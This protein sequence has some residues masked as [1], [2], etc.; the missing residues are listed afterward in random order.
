MTMK[1]I[2]TT[3]AIALAGALTAATAKAQVCSNL[4]L[5]GTFA[6]TITGSITAPPALAGPFASVGTQTFDG[7]GGTTAKAM[8]SQNGTIIPVTITGTYSVNPDCTGTFTL[9]ISPLGLTTHTFF[10][11]DHVIDYGETEF[12]AVLT[13]PGL[14]VTGIARRLFP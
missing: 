14:V 8:V 13:D 6:Y 9:Q 3:L 7:Q 12:Q 1:P 4:S 10:V 11:I 5:A 2:T